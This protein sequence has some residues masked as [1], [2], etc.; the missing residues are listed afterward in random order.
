MRF[1][2]YVFILCLIFYANYVLSGEIYLSF[3]SNSGE[4]NFQFYRLMFNSDDGGIKGSGKFCVAHAFLLNQSLT[5]DTLQ[6]LYKNVNWSNIE[7]LKKLKL[8]CATA[9][10]D[11]DGT[12]Y[13]DPIIF[14][15]KYISRYLFIGS[16]NS[17]GLNGKLY[18]YNEN[19]ITRTISPYMSEVYEIEKSIKIN[20]KEVPN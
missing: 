3:Q 13:V 8:H 9:Y 19:R 4:N 7:Q 14:E 12:F 15:P 20:D 17:S 6:L 18:E 10:F 5:E 11:N 16:I 2:K 1:T